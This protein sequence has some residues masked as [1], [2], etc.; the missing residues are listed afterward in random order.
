MSIQLGSA[1]RRWVAFLVRAAVS[2]SLIA[3]ILHQV[4]WP[5]LVRQVNQ[6]APSNLAL[7]M[8]S[9][10]LLLI[11]QGPVLAWRWSRIADQLRHPLRFSQSTRITF[12]GL[13]FNQT[14]P[15]SI[16]GD[17]IRIWIA[18][19]EG[20]PF[21]HA[22]NSVLLERLSGLLTLVLILTSALPLIWPDIAHLS[23]RFLFLAALPLAL[24]G[25]GA[26]WWSAGL[27]HS[28]K[29][30][31]IIML[32]KDMRCILSSPGLTVELL[33]LGVLSNLL[34]I[35]G[36]YAFGVT[37]GMSLTAGQYLGLIPAVILCTVVP[38]TIAGWG[39]RE[40]VMVVLLG[41]AGVSTEM[42]LL[43]SILFGL[44]LLLAALPGGLI[45]LMEKPRIRSNATNQAVEPI[46]SVK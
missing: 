17:A 23:V 44:A 15:T 14:L 9:A 46:D 10:T 16:G 36:M 38:V 25:I 31:P 13:F 18:H 39:L 28:K 19:Q 22:A 3:W 26:L 29:L 33:T 20:M 32:A 6:L 5:E 21:R 27:R 42:G 43:V 4:D 41:S 35:G 34:A 12:V 40:G 11:L 7:A 45:W 1:R 8:S 2:I 37:V 30:N 24:I